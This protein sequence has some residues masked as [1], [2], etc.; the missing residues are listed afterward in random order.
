[1][2]FL[3]KLKEFSENKDKTKIYV[4]G[5]LQGYES[6]YRVATELKQRDDKFVVKFLDMGDSK[7]EAVRTAMIL[8]WVYDYDAINSYINTLKKDASNS[9]Y[10]LIVSD[11]DGIF[12]YDAGMYP[13]EI[14][15][16]GT[17]GI[18]YTYVDAS[19]MTNPDHIYH[20]PIM[21]QYEKMI[22]DLN[23]R[24]NK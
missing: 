17:L 16:L 12:R 5:D 3:D 21:Y 9:D 1:M 13:Y 22:K 14:I 19:G 7:S 20:S 11:N 8:S 18:P 23:E 10:I 15:W 4:T 24:E 6:L 2:S